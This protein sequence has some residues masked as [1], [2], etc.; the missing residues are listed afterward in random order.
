MARDQVV[1]PLFGEFVSPLVAPNVA[2]GWATGDG[3]LPAK[4]A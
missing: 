1:G 2:M 3:D 4:G